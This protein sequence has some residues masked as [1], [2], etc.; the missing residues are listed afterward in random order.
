MSEQK[1]SK[2]KQKLKQEFSGDGVSLDE[3]NDAWFDKVLSDSL[4]R[5]PFVSLED[6]IAQINPGNQH[7]LMSMNHKEGEE[8]GSLDNPYRFN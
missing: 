5:T 4:K 6:L 7:E 8:Y 1:K 3:M 2:L